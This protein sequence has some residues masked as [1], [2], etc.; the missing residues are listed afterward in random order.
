MSFSRSGRTCRFLPR[1]TDSEVEGYLMHGITAQVSLYPLGENDLSPAIDAA[2]GEFDRHGLER[3]TGTMSTVVCG[4][5]EK[6]FSA[7]LDA[8]RGAAAFGQA[9]MV[10]TVS[11]ACPW[12]G[13]GGSR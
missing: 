10:V 13:K 4:D 9:V 6:V 2:I 5:D 1:G 11:N 8:F 7:L 12:P 3:Q